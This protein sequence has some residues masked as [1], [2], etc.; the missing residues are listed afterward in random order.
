MDALARWLQDVAYDDVVDAGLAPLVSWVVRRN[1]IRVER[2]PR[3][4]ERVQLRTWA[5]GE[6]RLWAERRTSITGEDGAAVESAGLWISIDPASGRPLRVPEQVLATYASATQ[7]RV[8]KARLRHPPPADGADRF[9]WR[10]RASD[11]DVA[12]H[13]NNA[14]YWAPLEELLAAQAL[15]GPQLESLDAEIEFRDPAQPGDAVVLHE[16]GRLWI[17]ASRGEVHA[18][19]VTEWNQ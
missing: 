18:S 16:P 10:F 15:P 17:T 8:V 1:R 7:G 9:E 19:I 2:F 12:E 6:G 14:A 11:M 13:V 3:L 4:G 5:S